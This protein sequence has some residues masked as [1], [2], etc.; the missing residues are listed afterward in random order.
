MILSDLLFLLEITEDH[1]YR[2]QEDV[3]MILSDLLFLLEIFQHLIGIPTNVAHRHLILF[4]HLSRHL[5]QF[6]PAFFSQGREDLV[7]V[8]R[9]ITEDHKVAI[10]NVRRDTNE[11]L[12]AMKKEG[13]LAED[14]FHKAQD[15]VQNITN[16][17][18]KIADQTCQEKE[19]TLRIQEGTRGKKRADSRTQR[20]AILRWCR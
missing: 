10:R 1:L 11:L 2:S 8:V 12:K 15:Q 18:V 6:F 13:E 17:H 16:D 7:K 4:G 14:A 20:G 9:K 5:Y 3:Q 19:A